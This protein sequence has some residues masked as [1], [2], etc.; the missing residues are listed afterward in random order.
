MVAEQQSLRVET[1][2]MRDAT[3]SPP[4]DTQLAILSGINII[5][6]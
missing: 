3:S 4:P 2:S 6:S 5:L 1:G